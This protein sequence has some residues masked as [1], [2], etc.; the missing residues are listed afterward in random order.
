VTQPALD[1]A[2]KS[3]DENTGGDLGGSLE[4]PSA[5]GVQGIE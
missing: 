1:V 4:R 5:F 3:L 2:G